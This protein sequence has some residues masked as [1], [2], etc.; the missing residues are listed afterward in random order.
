LSDRLKNVKVAILL[1]RCNAARATVN[2]P[3]PWTQV[4]KLQKRI[5]EKFTTGFFKLLPGCLASEASRLD[6]FAYALDKTIGDG[7][8]RF[9]ALVRVRGYATVRR[10][11]GS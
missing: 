4:A 5:F 7:N 3:L 2:T 9:A 1:E 8:A 6:S 10:K 11:R